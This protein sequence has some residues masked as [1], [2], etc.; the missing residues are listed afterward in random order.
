MLIPV[1]TPQRVERL[2]EHVHTDSSEMS[3]IRARESARLMEIAAEA[4]EWDDAYGDDDDDLVKPEGLHLLVTLD[5]R[6]L[7]H[8]SK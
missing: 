3:E 8:I 2:E 6:P 5:V 7:Y 4:A 1:V